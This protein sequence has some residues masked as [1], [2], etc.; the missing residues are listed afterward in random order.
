MI[1]AVVVW[2]PQ[3]VVYHSESKP[4]SLLDRADQRV[5]SAVGL[6]GAPHREKRMAE[7]HSEMERAQNGRLCKPST[8]CQKPRKRNNLKGLHFSK[9][10]GWH[11]NQTGWCLGDVWALATGRSKHCLL[12]APHFVPL[13]RSLGYQGRLEMPRERL[14]TAVNPR[15]LVT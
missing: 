11:I 12:S 9:A 1:L 2:I 5:P 3:M 14:R 10:S 6:Q 7:K 4:A 15:H 8:E 13:M